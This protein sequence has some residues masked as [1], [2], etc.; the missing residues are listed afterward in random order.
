VGGGEER[1]G[2]CDAVTIS[3][4]PHSLEIYFGAGH[5]CARELDPLVYCCAEKAEK[6]IPSIEALEVGVGL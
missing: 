6:I 4:T 5:G 2:F 1:G 3:T